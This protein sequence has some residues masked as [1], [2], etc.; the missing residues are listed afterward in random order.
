MI[1]WSKVEYGFGMIQ[2]HFESPRRNGWLF[3]GFRLVCCVK[4]L[5]TFT[6][7]DII[8]YEPATHAGQVTLEPVHCYTAEAQCSQVTFSQVTQTIE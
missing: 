1:L 5:F 3:W 2:D 7:L 8:P 6:A 4:T